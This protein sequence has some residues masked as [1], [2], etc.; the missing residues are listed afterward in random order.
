MSPYDREQLE[1]L[2]RPSNASVVILQALHTEL[3]RVP[4]MQLLDNR[5]T[6]NAVISNKESGREPEK[7]LWDKSNT[8]CEGEMILFLSKPSTGPMKLFEEIFK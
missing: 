8:V 4:D 3:G 5:N 6:L 7:A 1:P 2:P